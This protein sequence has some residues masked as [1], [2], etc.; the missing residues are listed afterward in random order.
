MNDHTESRILKIVARTKLPTKRGEFQVI[1]FQH[2]I[3]NGC[4]RCENAVALIM[5]DVSKNVPLV[6][7]HSECLTGEA[8]GSLRCDCGEQLELALRAIS[9]EGCGVLIYEHQEGRGIGLMAKLQAYSLQDRGLD[10]VEANHALGF[11]ADCRD[12]ATPLA[13]LRELE[14]S[15][16]R[17]LSNN[18]QKSRCLVKGGIDVV[19]VVPCEAA[20]NTYSL[21]YLRAKKEKM[22]HTLVLTMEQ[23]NFHTDRLS[24]KS[25][26]LASV[27][28]ALHELRA[29]RMIVVTD[30]EDRE[31]EGDLLMAA[32]MATPESINFMARHGCGLICLAMTNERADELNLGPMSR[33]NTALGGTGFTVS[34]DAR[35]PG[36]TTGISARDRAWT[37]RRAVDSRYA[38][39][40]F[41]RPGH[42]FPLRSRDGGVLERRGHTEAAVDLARLAG[43]SPAG[44]ICEILN[45]DGTMARVPDLQRFCKSHQLKMLTIADLVEYRLGPAGSI[46]PK[47]IYV[48][49]LEAQFSM[50][51]EMITSP[52]PPCAIQ[53]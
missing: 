52:K 5:G 16:V 35:G 3:L 53:V 30:D 39:E 37:I 25:S 7:I 31:N 41:A 32:D 28:E 20:P 6:R 9:K 4:K 10:T 26:A 40:D 34:I 27:E 36:M 1:G 22:G 44:V 46:S 47:Q 2:E 45:E 15:R 24:G 33:E 21:G 19:E 13:I 51:T 38:P 18:P 23:Q 48:P 50:G 29:G 49:G 43:L 11:Q 8:L 12:F 42:V 17:L 14:V